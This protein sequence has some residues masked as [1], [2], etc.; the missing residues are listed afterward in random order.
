MIHIKTREEI[1]IMRTGGKIL[2]EVLDEVLKNIKPGVSELELDRLAERLIL[3]KGGEPGFKK[4]EGYKHT[5]CI[6][7]NDVVVEPVI[8]ATIDVDTIGSVIVDFAVLDEV[9]AA[10]DVHSMG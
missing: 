7:T 1:E 5:I 4:V 8:A 2:A 9:I 10:P 6:S 3:E